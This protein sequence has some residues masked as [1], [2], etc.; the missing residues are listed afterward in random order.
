MVGSI[1]ACQAKMPPF[2]LLKIG[3][4]HVL[5]TACNRYGAAFAAAAH[6]Y[7]RL[8][9][10]NLVGFYQYA[11][12]RYMLAAKVRGFVFKILADV[13]QLKIFAAV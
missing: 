13:Y 5:P 3:V 6:Y 7:N 4:S 8:I 10:G 2:K 1:S 11:A 9:F 12:K